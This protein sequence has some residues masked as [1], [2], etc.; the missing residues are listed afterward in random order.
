MKIST[1]LMETSGLIKI[2]VV[3]DLSYGDN[4]VNEDNRNY[5]TTREKA[6]TYADAW[7]AHFDKRRAEAVR[8][9]FCGYG[10]NGWCEV[11]E[12]ILDAEEGHLPPH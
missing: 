7:N 12:I 9:S 2:W 6:D 8:N 3:V 1:R 5:F 11:R 4:W 10:L